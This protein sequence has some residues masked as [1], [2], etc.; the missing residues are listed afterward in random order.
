MLTDKERCVRIVS[1][2]ECPIAINFVDKV[3]ERSLTGQKEYGT[4]MMR[5]DMSTSEWIDNVIEELA[6]AALYLERLKVQL[7]KL[8][9]LYND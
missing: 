9:V 7:D 8:G 3:A 1:L 6:D 4:T 2:L 5:D